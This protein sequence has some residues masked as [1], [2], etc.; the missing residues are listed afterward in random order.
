MGVNLFYLLIEEVYSFT[1]KDAVQHGVGYDHILSYATSYQRLL[2]LLQSLERI[3][4]TVVMS[5][6]YPIYN[7]LLISVIIQ[8]VISRATYPE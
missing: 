8:L 4:P 1:E 6:V 5:A 3:S 7:I 2:W